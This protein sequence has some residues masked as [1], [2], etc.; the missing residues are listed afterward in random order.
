ML[1]EYGRSDSHFYFLR[2]SP[3]RLKI[4]DGRVINETS[5]KHILTRLLLIDRETRV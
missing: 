3:D 1:I 5:I 2:K 4:Q